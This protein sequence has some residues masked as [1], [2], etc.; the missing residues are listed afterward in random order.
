[1]R[2]AWKL[3]N[4]QHAGSTQRGDTGYRN[5]GGPKGQQVKPTLSHLSF[6]Q[7]DWETTE[8]VGA[9]IYDERSSVLTRLIWEC[10][11]RD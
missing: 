9:R 8:S 3:A 7:R 10:G 11:E 6:L 5:Y 1:M 4:A 2:R